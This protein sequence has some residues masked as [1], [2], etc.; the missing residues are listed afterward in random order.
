M[1]L[2]RLRYFRTVM[3]TGGLTRA[4]RLAHVTPGALSKAIRTLEAEIDRRLFVRAGRKLVP[5]DEAHRL[6]ASSERIFEEL[7]RL[8]EDLSSEGL[9]PAPQAIASFEVFT[10]SILA[11]LVD[12]G[13]LGGELRIV[14]LPTRQI[15]RAV[16]DRRV[17]VGLTYVPYPHTELSFRPIAKM[18]FGI[19][20]RQKAFAGAP[21]RELPFAVPV[22]MLAAAPSG[23][24]AVD[25]W[26]ERVPRLV[27]YRLSMLQTAL[28]LA[29]RGHC[30]VFVPDVVA[31]L[32][33]EVSRPGSRLV[34]R[35]GP[36]ELSAVSQ[37][38][39]L[40]TRVEQQYDTR[41]DELEKGLRSLLRG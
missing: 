28:E 15:E 25:G 34:K 39:Y 17:D 36:R 10:T 3:E 22:S 16:L 20:V 1:D 2:E 33:N 41:W 8:R 40:V 29:S 23:A 19:Y 38:A 5:T 30:A 27:R 37:T 31:K 21:F 7:R 13:V 24:P 32:R 12:R 6:Y 26:P 35:R 18:N 9:H 4:A 11:S 14:D